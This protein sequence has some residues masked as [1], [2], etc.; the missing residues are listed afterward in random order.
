MQR[1]VVFKSEEFREL[2]FE[3]VLVYCSMKT[4]RQLANYL[5]MNRNV[6]ANY[7]LGKLTLPEEIFEKLI[8]MFNSSK[9][10]FFNKKV[11]YVNANWGRIEGGKSTY[12]K[13]SEIFEWGRK[14]AIEI[15][16][17]RAH[18]FDVNLPLN[19]ELAYFIGLF[20]GDGFT[21]KYQRYYIIQFTGDKRFEKEFYGGLISEYSQKL[22]NLTPSIREEKN[23]NALRFNLYSKELFD[24]ITKRFNISAGRKSLTVLLPQEILDSKPSIIKACL[25]GLYDAEGC[26][27]FDKR[28]AYKKPYV[29]IAIHMNNLKILNQVNEI[30]KSFGIYCNF[31]KIKDNLA[32]TIY[33][34]EQVRKFVKEI[35]FSN[36]KHLNKLRCF[37]TN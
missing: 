8:S 29:R 14:K 20:I 17:E 31:C 3:D 24:L 21:N 26:V 11:S 7:R 32:L 27:F 34:E 36:P 9:K 12:R 35:G 23:T 4:W 6:L 28:K 18:K 19:E 22:F 16:K 2:F 10:D 1:R 5:E 30:L 33:G 15:S 37:N 13:H 25:R